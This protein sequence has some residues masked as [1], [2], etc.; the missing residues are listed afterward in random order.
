MIPSLLQLFVT[1]LALLVGSVA[2]VSLSLVVS[3]R[4]RHGPTPTDSPKHLVIVLGSGGH[5]AEMM[6]MLRQLSCLKTK[7]SHRTY[8]VSLGDDFS[9]SRAREFEAH[10]SEPA[11]GASDRPND[12]RSRGIYSILTVT[13]AR[14]IHQSLLTTPWSALLCLKDCIAALR[15]THP[16]Q[17][18]SFSGQPADLI[19]TNGPGTGVCVVL[20]AV[21]LRVLHPLANV[22]PVWYRSEGSQTRQQFFTPRTR[23]VFIESWARVTTLSLSGKVLLPLVDRFLVQWPSLQGRGNGRAEYV[24]ALV[25]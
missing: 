4:G 25:A 16:D 18:T 9:A 13:R 12:D 19:I 22:F 24:G 21:I 10:V 7:F 1:A 15:G 8:I 2:A 17:N 5:T 11:P 23:T 3:A 20:A 14:R 6:N